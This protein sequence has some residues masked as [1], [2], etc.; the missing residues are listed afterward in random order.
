MDNTKI[1]VIGAGKIGGAI[2]I[3]LKNNNLK[4]KATCR[5]EKRLKELKSLGLD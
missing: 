1:A 3:A 2:A 5:T 4:V